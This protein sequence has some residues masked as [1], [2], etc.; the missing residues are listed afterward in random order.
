MALFVSF[1]MPFKAAE[2]KKVE[3]S[4]ALKENVFS[5]YITEI[6][7]EKYIVKEITFDQSQIEFEKKQKIKVKYIQKGEEKEEFVYAKVVFSLKEFE[8]PYL[9]YRKEK[10]KEVE[11]ILNLPKKIRY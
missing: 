6:K 3:T 4:A 1:Y 9:E 11:A 5:D 8:K 7:K 2:Y 10:N